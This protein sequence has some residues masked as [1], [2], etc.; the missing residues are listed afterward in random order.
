MVSKRM[1]YLLIFV[2]I[3]VS[4]LGGVDSYGRYAS[5]SSAELLWG[6]VFVES[7]LFL[8]ISFALEIVMLGVLYKAI[9]RVNPSIEAPLI[10]DDEL[11]P[12]IRRVFSKSENIELVGAILIW[13]FLIYSSVN[14][15]LGSMKGLIIP[16][17]EA[18]SYALTFLLLCEILYFGGTIL[19]KANLKN[20]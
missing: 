4:I 11:G 9:K 15:T 20:E 13:N 7:L 16:V 5:H 18:S 6:Y 1:L 3:V 14:L 8:V 12:L 19:G 17:L 2:P 10:Q